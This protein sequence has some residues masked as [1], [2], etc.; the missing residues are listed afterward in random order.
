M[1]R[2]LEQDVTIKGELVKLFNGCPKPS[3]WF[4]GKVRTPDGR[5]TFL[6]PMIIEV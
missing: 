6:L 4:A 1:D 3:G 5:F 2:L